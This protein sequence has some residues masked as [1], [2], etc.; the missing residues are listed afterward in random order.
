MKAFA[1]DSKVI[2]D[3]GMNNGDD[4]A[5]YLNWGF[6]VVAL[7]ANPALCERAQKRFGELIIDLR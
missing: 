3:L 4:T 1:K 2:F 5:F 6:N 7:E